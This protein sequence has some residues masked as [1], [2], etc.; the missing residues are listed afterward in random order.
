VGSRGISNLQR[1]VSGVVK[2]IKAF[3]ATP[4]IVPAMGSHGG[5]TPEGQVGLLAEYG[6]TEEAL[7]AGIEA[8]MDT[9]LIG[10]TP[11]G[12]KVFFS[13]AALQADG[14][15]VINRVKPHTDF[16]SD[17]L[18]SGILKMLVIGLGKR[19]GAANFHAS[20]S[21][22]GYEHVIRTSA[23]ITLKKTPVL[24]G[25]AIL[26]NQRHETARIELL[27]P[28]KLEEDE[29]RL[30]REAKQLM[31]QLPMD[32]IDLLIIDRLGK[33]ISGAG[34]DPNVIG[35]SIHGYSS[36]LGERGSKPVVRRIFVRDLTPETHGNAVGIGMA[37]FTTSRLVRGINQ[38]ISFLNA[39]TALTPQSVQ[40][41]IHFETDREVLERALESLAMA[42]TRQA[43]VVRIGDTLS[44]E[45]LQMSE[46]CFGGGNE[47]NLQKLGPAAEMDFLGGNLSPMLS[48]HWLVDW[49][50]GFAL[51]EVIQI[52]LVVIQGDLSVGVEGDDVWRLGLD[53]FGC[54]AAGSSGNWQAEEGCAG[55]P[56][57]SDEVDESHAKGRSTL[58]ARREVELNPI[59][60][61]F[62][63]G[64]LGWASKSWT[65]VVSRL[66]AKSE[67]RI[68]GAGERRT[69]RTTRS[70]GESKLGEGRIIA[71]CRNDTQ[72]ADPDPEPPEET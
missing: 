2:E 58:H 64:T 9:A 59:K 24:C 20:A 60:G 61:R 27:L 22:H 33:N 18:G 67:E 53:R 51:F 6:I 1:I 44:L 71:L 36:L 56:D 48:A 12:V 41:P 45:N 42:D 32:D 62:L 38:E 72:A 30:Y 52:D 34:M 26:E 19:T 54:R 43:R 46:A 25:I 29:T 55:Q 47:G 40:I 63:R 3:G 35:R 4:F 49:L 13:K 50:S 14:V 8:S 11:E 57:R 15:V 39:L 37:D 28:E 7:G 70:V 69:G 23:R 17:T 31:P 66:R 5:A 16:V 21:R 65:L 68:Q 10:T